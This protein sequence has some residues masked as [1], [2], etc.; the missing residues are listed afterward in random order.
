MAAIFY[1]FVQGE[2]QNHACSDQRCNTQ[3][4]IY[5]LERSLYT[6][7]PR[8]NSCHFADDSF[9]CIFLNENVWISIKI[10]LK[11]VLRGPI[12]NIPAL[13][14]IMAWRR[15]GGKPLSEPMMVQWAHNV[16]ITSLLRHND[17]ATSSWLNNN[18]IITS[19]GLYPLG[20]PSITLW[21]IHAIMHRETF[22][23]RCNLVVV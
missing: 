4:M 7:R 16:T 3:R 15:L 10:S 1:H 12:N 14:Q 11:F 19:R 8:Q 20:T 23:P 22:S 13:V 17:V 5:E 18:V 21:Y 2:I 6:L 9:K